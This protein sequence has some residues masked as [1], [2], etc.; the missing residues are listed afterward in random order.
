MI[1]T[2]TTLTK[3]LDREGTKAARAR[4]AG[5]AVTASTQY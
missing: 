2:V 4:A 3:S 1:L 5:R